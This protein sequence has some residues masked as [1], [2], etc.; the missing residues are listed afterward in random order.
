MN[1]IKS[2]KW[3]VLLLL[4][5]SA[6]V[7]NVWAGRGH[8]HFGVAI[9]PY[10][11]PAYYPS[12]FYYPPYSPPYYSPITVERAAPQVYIEQPVAPSP[13]APQVVQTGYWY[14]CHASKA[15]Y[16]YAKECPGGWQKVLP[17]PPNQP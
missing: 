16:P 13:P 3:G 7:G 5:A 4:L 17:Q 2:I 9:G 10:W 12:P 1:A 14:Y 6:G 11:G 15:Y 8:V